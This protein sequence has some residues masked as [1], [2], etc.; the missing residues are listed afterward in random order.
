[1][2]SKCCAHVTVIVPTKINDRHLS[3]QLSIQLNFILDCQFIFKGGK[4]L[5]SHFCAIPEK[6]ETCRFAL[7]WF[8]VWL[9][10]FN[11]TRSQ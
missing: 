3:F 8:G 7:V 9:V 6:F 1:M 11:Y 4:N 2:P 5:I 10:L